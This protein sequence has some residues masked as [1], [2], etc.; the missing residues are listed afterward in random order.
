MLDNMWV[1]LYIQYI[2]TSGH[3]PANNTLWMVPFKPLNSPKNLKSTYLT[4]YPPEKI[5]IK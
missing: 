4:N 5:K 2:I 1:I 3:Y